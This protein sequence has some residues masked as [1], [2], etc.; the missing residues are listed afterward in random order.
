LHSSKKKKAQLI[1]FVSL[2]DVAGSLE[3]NEYVYV[4]IFFSLTFIIDTLMSFKKKVLDAVSAI[5]KGETRSYKEVA[6]MAGSPSAYRAVG[7]IMKKNRNPNVPCHRVVK[8][9]GEVGGYNAGGSGRK[10][11]ILKAEGAI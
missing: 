8:S 4:F 11:E 5:P 3:E 10:A 1:F 9:S 7:N 2:A 6:A